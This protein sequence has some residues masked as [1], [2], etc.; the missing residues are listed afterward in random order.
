MTAIDTEAGALVRESIQAASDHLRGE[1]VTVRDPRD[2]TEAPALLGESL[3]IVSSRDFDAYRDIPLR[4]EGTANHTRLDSFIAH[5]NRFKGE[6]SAIFAVDNMASPRLTAIFDYHHVGHDSIPANLK[7]QSVYSF[8]LSDEWKSWSDANGK[9]MAMSDFAAFL[10]D[11]IVDVT[12]DAP[13]SAA[14][15]DFL[16]KSGG[17]LASPSKLIEIAR[18]LQVNETSTL[19]EARNLS[20]GEAEVVFQSEHQDANGNK[21]VLPNAFMIC[22]PVFARARVYD[23]ILARFRYRKHNGGIVFWFDLWRPDMVFE[24]AFTDA[25]TQVREETALPLFVGKPEA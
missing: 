19:R 10:E 11:H 15:K 16:A 17:N 5:V 7:H 12:A 23:Q 24:N 14:A 13:S 1:M 22:I 21:L 4:R 25:C 2:G 20:S 18:G 6:N 8:P 9:T 3:H